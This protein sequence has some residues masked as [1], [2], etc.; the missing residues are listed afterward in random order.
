MSTE[1]SKA[2]EDLVPVRK[3][4]LDSQPLLYDVREGEAYIPERQ[5][6]LLGLDIK[7]RESI[8]VCSI[9][10]S[11]GSALLLKGTD[12]LIVSLFG[13]LE[14]G[15]VVSY[16]EIT[17]LT[18]LR[19]KDVDRRIQRVAKLLSLAE[20]MIDATDDR[21]GFS[22]Q[23]LDSLEQNSA[24]SKLPRLLETDAFDRIKFFTSYSDTTPAGP[25]LIVSEEQLKN[26]KKKRQKDISPASPTLDDIL[27]SVTPRLGRRS[28]RARGT[29][30]FARSH[31][32]VENRRR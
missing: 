4:S 15:G 13:G 32:G 3:P 9:P 31:T 17:S 16:E 26:F 28:P 8:P 5:H 21:K 22:I 24:N 14:K 18:N 11:D 12:A 19:R 27:Y 23:P 25:V 10:L 7:R 20:V 2:I 1:Y 6:F 29:G 30:R